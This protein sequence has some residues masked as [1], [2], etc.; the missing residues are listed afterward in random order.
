MPFNYVYWIT[1]WKNETLSMM[2]RCLYTFNLWTIKILSIVFDNLYHWNWTKKHYYWVT[3]SVIWIFAFKLFRNVV[4]SG[5]NRQYLARSINNSLAIYSDTVNSTS[6]AHGNTICFMDVERSDMQKYH[7]N[8][9]QIKRISSQAKIHYFREEDN[10]W[11]NQC[12]K[13]TC[14]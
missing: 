7:I 3:E 11:V 12:G 14:I 13:V 8:N 10:L 1:D 2:T 6:T 5:G 4:F 9:I